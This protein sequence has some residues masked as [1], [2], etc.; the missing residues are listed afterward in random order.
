AAATMAAS[1]GGASGGGGDRGGNSRM[2]I[3]NDPRLNQIS[4]LKNPTAEGFDQSGLWMV[5]GA[6]GAVSD[7]RALKL[8][9]RYGEG[10]NGRV[11]GSTRGGYSR[12]DM[13]DGAE[14]NPAQVA[15]MFAVAGY[16]QEINNDPAAMDAAR[17]AAVQSGYHKPRGFVQGLAANMN[18]AFGGT[19]AK[20]GLGK[21]QFQNSMY[22]AAVQ[23]SESYIRGRTGNAYTQYLVSRYGEWDDERMDTLTMI[24]ADPEAAESAWNAGI[25]QAT[26]RLI[27]SGTKI[28]A[29]NR[30][31]ALNPYCASLRPAAAGSAIRSMVIHSMSDQRVVDA[32]AEEGMSP[33]EFS[34][35]PEGGILVGEVLRNMNP[36][37]ARAIHETFLVTN[38][39]DMS[40]H[41]V[42]AVSNLAIQNSIPA[43]VAY[44]AMASNIGG[45]AANYMG[46]SAFGGC[47]TFDGV[48]QTCVE[49]YGPQ[50]GSVAYDQ[51]VRVANERAQL[52]ISAAGRNFTDVE[53]AS[54]FDGV[55]EDAGG[56]A[57]VIGD[58]VARD[59]GQSAASS[60]GVALQKFGSH[61]VDS[62]AG[63]AV[64]RYVQDGNTGADRLSAQE[65]T[66]AERLIDSG[67]PRLS[68]SL[69]Q[70]ARQCDADGSRGVDMDKMQAI[71]YS[72]D[73]REIRADQ[74]LAAL[75]VIDDGGSISRDSVEVVANLMASDAYSQQNSRAVYN[76]VANGVVQ[77]A[78]SACTVFNMAVNSAAE[79]H[80]S[81]RAANG[82]EP[83]IDMSQSVNGMLD[84][85]YGQSGGSVTPDVIAGDIAN[86]KVAGNFEDRQLV[87][88][89]MFE[90]AYS[91]IHD[92]AASSHRL[93]SI[94]ITE[95]IH[96]HGAINSA[97]VL[98][99]Y[100][101]LL[102]NGVRPNDLTDDYVGLQRYYAASAMQDAQQSFGRP[103][104][105][106]QAP[107]K[108]TRTL[109]RI[110]TD[111]RF[112]MRNARPNN[113]P[114]MDYSLWDDLW[115]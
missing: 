21:A 35:T 79:A 90:A 71:A 20:T 27:A 103:A 104:G 58:P 36:E 43:G 82:Q 105:K 102:E 49:Q 11:W 28:S 32:A 76:L 109:D 111:S 93:Q 7:V 112:V 40:E 108:D 87:D 39:A 55:I 1:S 68:Q 15:G 6:R 52:G 8:Q 44:K 57:S 45:F 22:T 115:R 5:A 67:V 95:R 54:A 77:N 107:A 97:N 56:W 74:S 86:I 18:Q 63:S 98:N 34:N 114:A 51:I 19:W 50:A 33:I 73:K 38:G 47:T 83:N 4:H 60:F 14:E 16:S 10:K 101:D 3:A 46:N 72:V 53:V 91:A 113:P 24:A 110:R 12:I 31:A 62:R 88:P 99:V 64:F 96:G 48:R 37:T 17:E 2:N 30:G 65:I 75:K 42:G 23:G 70:V 41:I 25:T 106:S 59:R 9:V 89:V 66:I 94:R 85:L 69:I 29:A 84:Q 80:N 78:S 61:A 26:D 100:D 81:A 92:P 13:P